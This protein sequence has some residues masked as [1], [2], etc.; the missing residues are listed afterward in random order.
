MYGEGGRE[1]AGSLPDLMS[2]SSGV[3]VPY[4][5]PLSA[6]SHG[7]HDA[8]AVTVYF[9]KGGFNI[10]CNYTMFPTPGTSRSTV[11]TIFLISR[12]SEQCDFTAFMTYMCMIEP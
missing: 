6:A 3:D 7:S 12:F 5:G 10:I 8:V 4:S 9:R 11:Q 1:A 2:E